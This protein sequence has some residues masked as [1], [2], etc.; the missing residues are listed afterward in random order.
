MVRI[1]IWSTELIQLIPHAFSLLAAGSP[2]S[3]RSTS[4]ILSCSICSSWFKVKR[5][6]KIIQILT[7]KDIICGLRDVMILTSATFEVYLVI[8]WQSD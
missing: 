7:D 6:L 3:K 4:N 8:M 1:I 2:I 5:N